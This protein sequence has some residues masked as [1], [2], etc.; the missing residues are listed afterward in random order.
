MPWV[1]SISERFSRR[2]VQ[3]VGVQTPE[4]EQEKDPALVR[5][6]VARFGVRYPIVLDNDTRMWDALGTA[7]WPSLY[8]V[9]RKGAVR[10]EHVGEIHAG[11]KDAQRLE[12][13]IESLLRESS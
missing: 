7:A 10:V 4:F 11:T 5:A 8:L 12:A 3:V 1:A 13:Q 6:A 2:G 9:D